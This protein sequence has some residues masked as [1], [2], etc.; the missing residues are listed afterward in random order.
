MVHFGDLKILK[1][2]CNTKTEENI[3]LNLSFFLTVNTKAFHANCF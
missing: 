3:Y 2:C 1:Y